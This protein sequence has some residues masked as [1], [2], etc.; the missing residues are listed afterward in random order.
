MK[1][2]GL[3]KI[4]KYL[5]PVLLLLTIATYYHRIPSGDDA[6]FAEQSLWLAKEGIVRSNFFSGLLNWDVQ[7]LVYHKFFIWIGA[8]IYKLAGVSLVAF[9]SISLISTVIFV[10]LLF[11]YIRQRNLSKQATTWALFLVLG[12][13]SIV[14]MSFDNRPEILQMTLGFSSFLCLNKP[15]KYRA[16]LAGLLAGLALL[17]HLNG[18]IF[19]A[20]GFILLVTT[21]RFNEIIYFTL[22][23]IVTSGLYFYDVIATHNFDLWLYQL[24]K[25]PAVINS[26]G[27]QHK[28]LILV[29]FPLIFVGSFKEIGITLILLSL[30]YF[31]S[32]KIKNLPRNLTIYLIASICTF[33]LLTKS[34]TGF[35]Q[36][37]FLPYMMLVVIE[38]IHLIDKEAIVNKVI[39][40]TF[41]FYTVIC[42]FGQIQL[43]NE[44]H[45]EEYLPEKYAR[46]CKSIP[47]GSNGI[48]P[49]TF[50]FNEY[51]KYSKLYCLENFWPVNVY[52]ESHSLDDLGK[53]A[54]K[55]KA[56]F[57]LINKNNMTRK[58]DLNVHS[59][60]PQYK[61][62]YFDNTLYLFIKT[63]GVQ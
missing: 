1:K 59:K 40:F 6:W 54:L 43:L 34:I 51:E 22:A 42:L 19:I 52:G 3:E 31:G 20:S 44:N 2:I 12:N 50:F 46:I 33:W 18:L 61:L 58:V 45:K 10:F 39:L 28:L 13:I 48:V 37:L 21:R 41:F 15:N 25:D 36:L 62:T 26:L 17:T 57:I 5:L 38:L 35:Y 27:L 29:K 8:L 30:L 56:D 14:T 63:V 55:N 23:S 49:L 53:F 9:K 47:P 16:M 4:V 11:Q 60:I 32:N 24:T 7:I